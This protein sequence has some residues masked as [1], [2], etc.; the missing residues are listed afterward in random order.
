[1]IL[2]VPTALISSAVMASP[3]QAAAPTT[4]QLQSDILKLTNQA[5]VKNGCPA[6]RLD[7]NLAKA[8]R[9]HS[10]WM[11]GNRTMSH[12][13][14]GGSTFVNRA[15]AAGYNSAMSENVAWGYRTGVT[16]VNALMKSPGHRANILNCKAKAIGIGAAYA[17]N[18][19]PYYTQDFGSK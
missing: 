15:Q 9:N 16:V 13:G 11:A 4:V 3:A 5:R 18:G 14:A 17:A 2:I 7:A 6:L 1:M 19:N 12:V 8:A 10:A